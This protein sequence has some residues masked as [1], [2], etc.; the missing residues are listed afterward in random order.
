PRAMLFDVFA[1]SFF[2]PEEEMSAA[3]MLQYFHFYFMAN[4]ESLCFDVLDGPLSAILWDPLRTYL[5]ERGVTFHLGTRVDSVARGQGEGGEHWDVYVSSADGSS[6]RPHLT[7]DG[8]VLAANVQGLQGIVDRSPHLGN[9]HWRGQIAALEPTNPYAVLRLWYDGDVSPDRVPFA[10]TSGAGI[11]DSV[12]LYHR[13]EESSARWHATTGGAVI[14]LHAYAVPRRLWGDEDAIAQELLDGLHNLY[15]EVKNLTE[16]QRRYHVMQDCPAF[17]VN[18]FTS[19]PPV[20]TPHDSL[21]LAGDLCWIPMPSGLM[22]RATASGFLAANKL[23]S[24]W[25]VRG[26]TLYSV[27][28]RGILAGVLR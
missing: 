5:E 2:N 12:S 6:E 14:E 1:H 4:P 11:L 28:T 19:R 17:K 8:V 15:P 25:N 13:L 26:E 18:T 3:E 10:S 7:A 24:G 22:E 27:P 16:T 20:E 9:P 21:V 23:L